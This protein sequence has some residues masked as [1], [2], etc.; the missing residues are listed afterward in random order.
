MAN[1]R[2]RSQFRFGMEAMVVELFANVSIGA[3]GAPTLNQSASKGVASVVRDSAGQYTVTLQDKYN[4]LLHLEVAQQTGTSAAAAPNVVIEA[5]TVSSDKKF[6]IQMRA[7][8][9][10]TATDPANGSSLLLKI[11]L[12]NSS[13]A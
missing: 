1:R 8:D 13:V 12:S 11:T 7:S 2:F 3:S 9:N 5:N 6:T 10:S 4:S